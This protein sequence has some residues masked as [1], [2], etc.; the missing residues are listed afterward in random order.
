MQVYERRD[1]GT[2]QERYT[3]RTRAI[4]VKE[5]RDTSTSQQK[6]GSKGEIRYRRGEIL[7]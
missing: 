1:T 3:L 7:V 4:Q 2:G 5:R 6:T